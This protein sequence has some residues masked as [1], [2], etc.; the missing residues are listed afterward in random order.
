MSFADNTEISKD[1][2]LKLIQETL[3]CLNETVRSL[4]V[5]DKTK[6]IAARTKIEQA[7]NVLTMVPH[8]QLFIGA[9]NTL[10]NLKDQLTSYIDSDEI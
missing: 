2:Y 9:R 5:S 3:E 1:T 7:L 4:V 8:D 10:T 6:A